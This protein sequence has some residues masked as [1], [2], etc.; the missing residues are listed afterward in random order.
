MAGGSAVVDAFGKMASFAKRPFSSSLEL[1]LGSPENVTLNLVHSANMSVD[2]GALAAQIAAGIRGKVKHRTT[3]NYTEFVGEYVQRPSG[4]LKGPFTENV[5]N[6]IK[7]KI[8]EANKLIAEGGFDTTLYSEV[9]NSLYVQFGMN[10]Q[11]E[12]PADASGAAATRKSSMDS[13]RSLSKSRVTRREEAL[14]SRLKT[15]LTYI[16]D[17]FLYRTVSKPMIQGASDLAHNAMD[18]FFSTPT[19]FETSSEWATAQELASTQIDSL[20]SD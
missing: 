15:N 6:T 19:D 2:Q 5:L 3:F 11:F 7:E 1:A 18:A 8:T 17:A 10:V 9:Q 13:I 16:A 12:A 14:E 20:P 4:A